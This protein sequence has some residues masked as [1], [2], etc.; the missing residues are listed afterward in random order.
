VLVG[1]PF[2]HRCYT[3]KEPM[4]SF[5]IVKFYVP[6]QYPLYPAKTAIVEPCKDLLF[7]D[8]VI[9]LYMRIFLRC[10]HV[11]ELLLY[12]YQPQVLTHPDG[13]ELTSVIASDDHVQGIV[14]LFEQQG[15]E[16]YDMALFDIKGK[17]VL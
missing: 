14:V 7:Q 6:F 5:V 2:L 12:T 3:A 1:V 11:G 17:I 4:E 15:K 10:G 9:G 8:T 16:L 13:Y